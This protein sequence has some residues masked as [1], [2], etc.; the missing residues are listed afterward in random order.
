MQLSAYVYNT[1]FD[2]A[3]SQLWNNQLP[4]LRQPD[5][6]YSQFRHSRGRRSIWVLWPRRNMNCAQLCCI[7]ISTFTYLLIF[8]ILLHLKVIYLCRV[9]L[10]LWVRWF[11]SWQFGS[12]KS[13]PD[14]ADDTAAHAV[15]SA[16]TPTLFTSF[17]STICQLTRRRRLVS[18]SVVTVHCL[19]ISLCSLLFWFHCV[20]RLRNDLYCVGWGVKLYSLIS[21]CLRKIKWLLINNNIQNLSLLFNAVQ[22]VHDC[23]C[24]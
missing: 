14:W 5:L 4:Y 3:W 15:V 23:C 22:A 17:R 2:V 9:V 1:A 8:I 18:I 21:L 19:F 24:V 6:S 10:L 11:C 12:T 13:S 16:A 20:F 7:E